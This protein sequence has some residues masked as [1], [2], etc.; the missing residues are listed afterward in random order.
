VLSVKT[1]LNLND[2]DMNSNI[3]WQSAR[4]S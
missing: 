3:I 4:S 1:K 2:P